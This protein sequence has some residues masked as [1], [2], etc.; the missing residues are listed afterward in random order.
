METAQ[1]ASSAE[2]C[3]PAPLLPDPQWAKPVGFP[4]LVA[5]H[6]CELGANLVSWVPMVLIGINLTIGLIQ[7]ILD[8]G[9]HIFIGDALFGDVL[10]TGIGWYVGASPLCHARPSLLLGVPHAVSLPDPIM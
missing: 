7:G 8:G 9:K 6:P 2:D 1:P 3:L 5:H 10:I 4:P